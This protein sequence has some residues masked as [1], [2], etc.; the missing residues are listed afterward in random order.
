MPEDDTVKVEIELPKDQVHI[1]SGEAPQPEPRKRVAPSS[2]DQK[3]E[4]FKKQIAAASQ[5]AKQQKEPEGISP[6]TIPKSV[7]EISKKNTS[8]PN[9]SQKRMISIGLA[10]AL[11]G[12]ILWPLANFW[13]AIA[14]AVVGSAIIATAT[15][16]KV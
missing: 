11:V 1:V 14:V 15:F 4:K 7:D 3:I 2:E 10:V 5:Q 9:S 13:L 12:L 16:V 6:E 8:P